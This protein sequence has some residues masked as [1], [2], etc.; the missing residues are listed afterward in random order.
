M[1]GEAGEKPRFL[2]GTI[3]GRGFVQLGEFP[4][5]AD[6]V[7]LVRIFL[8]QAF[9]LEEAAPQHLRDILPR[10]R[11]HALFALPPHHR[12]QFV[13]HSKPDGILLLRISGEQGGDH[14]GA[15][16][17]ADR[18]H[19]MLKEIDDARLPLGVQP[20]LLA[21]VHQHLVHQHQGAEAALARDGQ[22]LREERFRRRRFA[23]LR[24]AVRM[25]RA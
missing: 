17:L 8:L 24:F 21:G 25:D 20:D 13:A 10:H 18:R 3:L 5:H 23:F 6:D 4:H 19:Q 9:A 2:G 22:Q 15:I 1:E 12:E 7:R 16:H 14:R 11:L